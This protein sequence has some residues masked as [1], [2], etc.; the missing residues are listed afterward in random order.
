MYHNIMTSQNKNFL[1][2][3]LIELLLVIVILGI[4]ISIAVSI[5]NPAK[6]QR[7][8]KESVMRAQ[9]SKVCAALLACASTY[10]G[11]RASCVTGTWTAGANQATG[12]NLDINLSALGTPNAAG[13]ATGRAAGNTPPYAAYSIQINNLA[14]WGFTGYGLNTIRFTGAMCQADNTTDA[15]CTAPAKAGAKAGTSYC[16]IICDYNF[17]T[18]QYQMVKGSGCY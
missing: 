8:S 9:V 10:G 5:I 11:D 15:T 4:V 6:I 16:Y 13:T 17:D 2:F 3:T 14:S 7:R 12:H 1:G 18:A